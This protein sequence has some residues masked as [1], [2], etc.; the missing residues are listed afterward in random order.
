MSSYTE[1][2]FLSRGPTSH[3]F[4]PWT[5]S[6]DD[7]IH[8]GQSQSQEESF[9]FHWMTLR[10]LSKHLENFPTKPQPGKATVIAV[11]GIL[12]VGTSRS[13]VL[14]YSLKQVFQFALGDLSRGE[15]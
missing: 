9:M 5:R 3:S 2:S 14:I 13:F 4:D 8:T 15:T 10:S 6:D 11:N 12:A 7:W 1:D